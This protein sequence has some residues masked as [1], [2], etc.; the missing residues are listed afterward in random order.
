MNPDYEQKAEE[1]SEMLATNWSALR[2]RL[3][4]KEFTKEETMELLKMYILG[5]SVDINI[6]MVDSENIRVELAYHFIY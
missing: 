5:S 2:T 3:I 4:D 6:D 1:L